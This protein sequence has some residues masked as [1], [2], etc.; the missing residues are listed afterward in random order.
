MTISLV[1]TAVLSLYNGVISQ[2]DSVRH[3]RRLLV[4]LR[5]SL[6]K[7][8]LGIFSR[9]KMAVLPEP[10]SSSTPFYNRVYVAATVLDPN[11]KMAWIDVDVHIPRT[12]SLEEDEEDLEEKSS[13]KEDVKGMFVCMAMYHVCMWHIVD[14]PGS[15]KLPYLHMEVG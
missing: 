3:L 10:D 2:L 15:S 14:E 9:V 8:F 6:Q 1:T 5:D 11:M 7:R 4:A 13:V 12:A